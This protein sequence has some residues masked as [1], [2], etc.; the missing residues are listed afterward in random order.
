MNNYTQEKIDTFFKVLGR[1][2]HYINTANTKTTVLTS[3]LIA[4]IA[5]ISLRLVLLLKEP[6]IAY[7]CD[8]LNPYVW[9]LATICLSLLAII[10]AFIQLRPNTSS[11]AN[12]Q[13]MIFYGDVAKHEYSA[14]LAAVN[15]ATPQNILDDLA[16]Q[17]HAVAEVTDNKFKYLKRVTTI[18]VW[19]VIPSLILTIFSFTLLKAS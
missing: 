14:F 5:G 3:F 6:K 11:D 2:D 19:F 13:S 1:Y 7:Y 15:K 8:L 18:I 17:V 16:R 10:F 12:Y 4:V 9:S